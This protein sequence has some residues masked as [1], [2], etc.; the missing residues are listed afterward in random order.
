MNM[1]L[2]FSNLEEPRQKAKTRHDLIEII[3]MTI[4]AVAGDCDGWDEIEDFCVEHEEWLRETLGMALE[5]GVP[6]ADTF[7]RVW[8]RLDSKEFKKSFMQWAGS[9][10]KKIKGEVISIDGKTSR[11]SEDED[12]KAIHMVSAWLHDQRLVLGQI[13]VEEKSNEITAVPELVK[14]LEIADCI[15]TADAMSCQKEIVKEIIRKKADYVIGLKG[16]QETLF[17]YAKLLFSDF[18]QNPD[19]YE[20][21]T[22]VETFD[23]GHGRIEKRIYRLSTDLS[24]FEQ[25][26]LWTGLKA[27]GTVHSV[28]TNK[29]TGEVTEFDRYYI[30]SVTDAHTFAK[31]VREH[32][33]IEAS[34]HHVLDVSFLEDASRIHK[35]HAADNLAVIRHFALNA[36]S[37]LDVGKKNVSARRKRKMCGRNPQLLLLALNKILS[38]KPAP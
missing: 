27:I 29:K 12:H 23:L 28:V 18:I 10:R 21:I 17:E 16:N 38:P 1:K 13:A 3:A 31:A 8:S 32:W 37:F 30:A 24:G 19:L 9:I 22:T 15:I 36:L 4:I 5:N 6:S 20:D 33:G 26:K 11:G 14:M 2:F 34:L 35:D 7:E 25:K